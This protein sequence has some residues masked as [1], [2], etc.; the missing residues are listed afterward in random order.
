MLQHVLSAVLMSL[1]VMSKIGQYNIQR[2]QLDT[3][4]LI[5]LFL[6]LVRILDV[7]RSFAVYLLYQI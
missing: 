3:R 1:K 7:H 4:E 6:N 5:N 2:L